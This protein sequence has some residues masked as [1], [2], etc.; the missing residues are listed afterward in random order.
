MQATGTVKSLQDFSNFFDHQIFL[1][2]SESNSFFSIK[3]GNI[4]KLRFPDHLKVLID[5]KKTFTKTLSKGDEKFNLHIFRLGDG[6][7]LFIQDPGTGNV[8]NSFILSLITL[9]SNS[10][11]TSFSATAADGDMNKVLL[12]KLVAEFDSEKKKFSITNKR[13]KEEIIILEEQAKD[14][15]LQLDMLTE[16]IKEKDVEIAKLRENMKS[17]AESYRSIEK[18]CCDMEFTGDFK[19]GTELK[20]K[21]EILKENNRQLVEML[22]KSSGSVSEIKSEV[23]TCV[24]ES[25]RGVQIPKEKQEELFANIE[26]IFVQDKEEAS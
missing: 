12:D 5:D 26:Q 16:T 10:C 20:K 21:N 19:I 9:S 24:K 15:Y 6:N 2:Q 3:N 23:E 22:K 14:A 17:L 7:T 11:D 8:L 25:L 18:K 1:H 13:Q 4:K